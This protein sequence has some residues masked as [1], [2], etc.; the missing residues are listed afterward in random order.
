VNEATEAEFAVHKIDRDF[1]VGTKASLENQ[2]CHRVFDVLLN[3]AL[4]GARAVERIK[5]HL[6]HLVERS[7]GDRERHLSSRQALLEPSELDTSDVPNVIPGQR[8]E[9]HDFVD[10]V[11]EFRPEMF[12]DLAHHG[13][14]DEVGILAC[15]AL[16]VV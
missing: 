15:K 12:T 13:L 10:P 3:S 7:I 9:H 11:D 4:E 8:M 6:G 5:A 14:L 2:P 16:D 1:V